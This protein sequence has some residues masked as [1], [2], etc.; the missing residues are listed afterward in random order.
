MTIEKS[1]KLRYRQRKQKREK[2]SSPWFNMGEDDDDDIE[3][4][5]QKLMWIG[6]NTTASRGALQIN[7]D[8]F[9][10]ILEQDRGYT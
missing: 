5:E 8:Q 7:I 6:F 2:Q 10:D 3:K 1:N 4:M 9:E